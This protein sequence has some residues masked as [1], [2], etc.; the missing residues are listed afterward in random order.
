M[1]VRQKLDRLHFRHD[2]QSKEEAAA[3]PEVGRE[4]EEDELGNDDDEDLDA[5]AAAEN[6]DEIVQ[7]EKETTDGRRLFPVVGVESTKGVEKTAQT[8]SDDLK[9]E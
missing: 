9:R 3:S 8:I 4:S 6:N 5:F 7:Y 2:E 1:A